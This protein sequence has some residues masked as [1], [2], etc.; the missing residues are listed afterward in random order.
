MTNG[1]GL[2][3]HSST[4]QSAI[5]VQLPGSSNIYYIFTLDD[6]AGVDGVRYS[7]VDIDLQSGL[8]E[9]VFQPTNKS[10]LIINRNQ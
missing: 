6:F 4:T 3:G 2:M 9:V 1:A 10:D 7:I 5:I 8:G